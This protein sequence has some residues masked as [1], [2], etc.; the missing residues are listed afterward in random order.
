MD[1][2]VYVAEYIIR[3]R[4][5]AARARA[6]FAALRGEA[7]QDSKRANGFWHQLLDVGRSL[8]NGRGRS[9]ARTPCPPA[10]G[11]LDDLHGETTV[12]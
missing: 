9:M 3:E 6:K 2:D 5:A 7:K 10:G 8:V 11:T 1:G 12:L 4:L